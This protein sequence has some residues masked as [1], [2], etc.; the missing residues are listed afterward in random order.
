[1]IYPLKNVANILLV[2]MALLLT[3]NKSYANNPL[4]DFEQAME[5][6][7]GKVVYLDFW[8]SW[9]VPCRKSF[10]WMNAMQTKHKNEGLI[11]L[12]VNLDTQAALAETFLQQTPANFAIIY[13]AKGKLAKKF[14]LK[15]MPSS[16]LF[17]RQGKIISAHSGFNNKKQQKY[18]QE[19]QKALKN[20]DEHN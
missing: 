9:C 4:D 14:K 18:E 17:N 20:K 11:V 15:G 19:I 3:S 16:Y 13:D 10:P 7:K 2:T 5:Q 6:Y 1:M 8:A 12:S